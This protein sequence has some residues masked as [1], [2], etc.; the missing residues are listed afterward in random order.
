MTL[1]RIPALVALIVLAACA[2][3]PR[4]GTLVVV[5]PEADG[6]VGRVDVARGDDTIVLDQARAAA[7]VDTRGGVAATSLDEAGVETNFGAALAAQPVPPRTFTLY[8]EFDSDALTPD[9]QTTFE[10]VFEDIS[11]RGHYEVTVVG[12]TDTLAEPAY[13]QELSLGR[14]GQI[15]DL[16]VERGIPAAAIT[17]FG[18]GE[19]DLLVAT[20]DNVAEPLNRRVEITV[21]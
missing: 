5:L 7:S 12:H 15:R 19:Y 10:Q 4:Q 8:F 2:E 9:S 18:R 11:A 17:A 13:N 6:G 1:A 3:P 16:L 21:R 14:A 20:A